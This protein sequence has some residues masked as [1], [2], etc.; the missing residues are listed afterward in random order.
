MNL[1]ETIQQAAKAAAALPANHPWIPEHW[2]HQKNIP[3]LSTEDLAEIYRMAAPYVNVK[4]CAGTIA[5]VRA[6][7]LPLAIAT[8][9]TLNMAK[10]TWGLTQISDEFPIGGIH[11]ER[12]GLEFG[13]IA[14][15]P[16][17]IYTATR[18]YQDALQDIEREGWLVRI[19]TQ[20]YSKVAEWLTHVPQWRTNFLDSV[21]MLVGDQD[22]HLIRGALGKPLGLDYTPFST[23]VAGTK[24]IGPYRTITPENFRERILAGVE[25]VLGAQ[26]Q[27]RSFNV[28]ATEF[29][30]YFIGECMMRTDNGEEKLLSI[31]RDF[32]ASITDL[33]HVGYNPNDIAQSGER[34]GAWY[35]MAMEKLLGASTAAPIIAYEF[36]GLLELPPGDVHRMV[37]FDE[38]GIMAKDWL[39]IGKAYD[40]YKILLRADFHS[41]KLLQAQQKVLDKIGE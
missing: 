37:F 41:P 10:N 18:E 22:L 6:A 27:K 1:A 14:E 39:G 2:Q 21:D 13:T 23:L 19:D 20:E 34:M 30:T 7:E 3:H 40:H 9:S 8:T 12:I 29:F 5:A 26:Q 4:E 28:D 25:A 38:G 33:S 16:L 17:L 31:L 24:N 32:D 35:L 11:A 15:K 36:K